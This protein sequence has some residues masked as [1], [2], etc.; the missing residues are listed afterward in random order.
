MRYNAYILIVRSEICVISTFYRS[1]ELCLHCLVLQCEEKLAWT[2]QS[3]G[4]EDHTSLHC[5]SEGKSW[6]R[7]PSP[8]G[9]SSTTWDPFCSRTSPGSN[10]RMPRHHGKVH[11]SQPP[12]VFQTRHGM[13]CHIHKLRLYS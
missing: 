2:C 10:R 1:R 9:V 11:R 6:W 3:G 12:C 13:Y 5:C 7:L 8:N 4:E